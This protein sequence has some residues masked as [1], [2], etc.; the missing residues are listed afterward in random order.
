MRGRKPKPTRLRLIEG[1]P[2]RRP[3]NG[4]EPK[5]PGRLPSCPAHLS[6]TAKNEWKRLARSRNV[7]GLLTQ[8]HR[9]PL[10]AYCQ[11]EAG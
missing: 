3:I 8:A 1:N 9:A 11:L 6:P 10:A 2:G 7:V 5:P 4:S